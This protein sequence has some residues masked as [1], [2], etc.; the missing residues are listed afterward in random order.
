M[1]IN[2]IADVSIEVNTG[3]IVVIVIGVVI[4]AINVSVG[5]IVVIVI[6]VVIEAINVSIG[7][8]LEVVY[9]LIFNIVRVS[10]FFPQTFFNTHL[11]FRSP[12]IMCFRF[13]LLYIVT[14]VLFGA[15]IF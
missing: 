10:L 9:Y 2:V 4:E 12:H 8:I 14:H 15:A 3:V 5:D 6:G 7:D 11:Y 1:V 13:R